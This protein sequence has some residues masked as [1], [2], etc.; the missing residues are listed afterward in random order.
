MDIN[1]PVSELPLV[2]PVY[3]KRLEHLEIR[4][5]GD[6]LLHV[7][8][9]Y[10]DFSRTVAITHAAIGDTIT[11]KGE[12]MSF[13]N[14][15]TRGGRQIEVLQL[16]DNTGTVQVV[17]FN[18]SYLLNSIHIG[19][20]LAVAGNL[21][22][23]GRKKAFISPEYGVGSTGR[24]VPIYPETAGISSK[25]LRA[26]MRDVFA[27]LTPLS[28]FLPEEILRAQGLVNYWQALTDIHF[29]QSLEDAQNGRLRLAFNELL[30]MQTESLR[31]KRLWQKHHTAFKLQVNKAQLT[32]FLTSLPFKLTPSQ[33]ASI[34]EIQTDLQK[35]IPMNRLLEGDVGSGKTV[36]AASAIF[37][38]F[39]NGYQSVFMAPT[40][41]LA[42]QHFDTLK[43]L[44]AP[45]KIRIALVTSAGIIKDLGKT[46]V[47]IGT[48]ALLHQKDLFD[49][50]ALVIIDEQHRFGVEQREKLIKK[51]GK[52]TS[53]PHILTM[54]ATPIPRTVA[55]SLY[56]DLDIST[57]KEMPTGRQKITTWLVPTSK[58]QAAYKWINEQISSTKSLAQVFIVCPLIEEGQTETTIS[59]KSAKKEFDYLTTVFPNL[60]LDLLHGK[61]SAK[62][63]NS[64]IDK[65]KSGITD[66]LVATP[67][68][69]VGLDVPNASIMVIEGAERFGLAQLHQLRGRVGRGSAKSYCLLFTENTSPKVTA[70]LTAMQ[71][72]LTGAELAELD[73]HL[74]GPGEIYG[75]RQHG[76]P[77]L[78]IASWQDFALIKKAKEVATTLLID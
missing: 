18:Q 46:D 48:Q 50:T 62:Q 35:D 24:I 66:I 70:R 55:L 6:L 31:K 72:N 61:L 29:P 49:K 39:T 8:H 58:R 27:R 19:D 37:T 30:A 76:I 16:Q 40:Q 47:F 21:T 23:F 74:R 69:E 38:A 77:A 45:F 14:Q 7:P 15:Y 44:F 32:G 2:G 28:E 59:V 67:V 3:Q 64:V 68:I 73:L 71:K 52:K 13:N 10:L 20:Q 53:V 57:L 11:V 78:K 42:Q 22:W 51:S 60:K 75:L 65:F 33:S 4:S 56:G 9:R 12:V 63:K 54:T 5:I 41:I 36:V 25:W 43:Q 26:R 34:D 1:S 17:W